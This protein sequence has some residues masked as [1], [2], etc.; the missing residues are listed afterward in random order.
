MNRPAKT[1]ILSFQHLIVGFLLVTKG[2][3]KI[4]HHFFLI[5]WIILLMGIAILGYFAYLKISKKENKVLQLIAHL[6]EGIALLLTAYVYFEEGKTY[7]P[8]I[9]LIAGIGFLVA[10]ILHIFKHKK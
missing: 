9:I 7:L 8:Y 10:T 5:G 3:E 1:D 2:Y 6:F 4:E